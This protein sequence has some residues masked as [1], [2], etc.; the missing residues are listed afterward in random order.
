MKS[1][2]FYIG[3]LFMMIEIFCCAS[4]QQR[5]QSHDFDH[6]SVDSS[7][8]YDI[9]FLSFLSGRPVLAML[10]NQDGSLQKAKTEQSELTYQSQNSTSIIQ[11]SF[12]DALH[13]VRTSFLSSSQPNI[14]ENRAVQSILLQMM[15]EN[16]SSQVDFYFDDLRK[17]DPLRW[18]FYVN[19]YKDRKTGYT[20]FMQAVIRSNITMM[21]FLEKSG[22]DFNARDLQGKTALHKVVDSS[23]EVV[24]VHPFDRSLVSYFVGTSLDFMSECK[25]LN[26][27]IQD[28]N[29]ATSLHIALEEGLNDEII[30]KLIVL[31]KTNSLLKNKFGQTAR[32][33]AQ[34]KKRL[35]IVQLIDAHSLD[36]LLIVS[37]YK[38]NQKEQSEPRVRS[39]SENDASHQKPIK[40]VNYRPFA[41]TQ[42]SYMPTGFTL[43][44]Q[45]Q[46]ARL[47]D[48]MHAKK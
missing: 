41:Q 14:N 26:P 35:A 5:S 25:N 4:Q 27:N 3:T 46:A 43:K 37:N 17:H 24:R 15:H 36:H 39:Y 6:L 30:T 13:N 31:F 47:H 18:K 40:L 11:E 29:G 20:L 45:Q 16:I 1:M 9:S 22:I 10:S 23:D 44:Q 12:I 38:N 28:F 7:S 19:S 8:D 34:N 42:S 21:R 2:K 48:I 33:I 32:D